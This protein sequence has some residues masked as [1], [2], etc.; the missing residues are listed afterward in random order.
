MPSPSRDARA[1]SLR[2]RWRTTVGGSPYDHRVPARSETATPTLFA[3]SIVAPLAI[4]CGLLAVAK[5]DGLGP[6]AR[7]AFRSCH[8]PPVVGVSAALSAVWV[9]W[10]SGHRRWSAGFVAFF[11]W[12]PF[13]DLIRKF[14]GN[15][16]RVYA[17]KYGLF[18]FAM[19][20]A[21]PKIRG[22]WGK[23]LGPL[24]LPTLFM[25]SVAFI[26]AIPSALS[27]PLIP[28]TGMLVRFLFIGLI[29]LGGYIGRDAARL[30]RFVFA[31]AGSSAA[32]CCVGLVQTVV[33]PEFLNPRVADAHLT[34]LL[35]SAPGV[36][37]PAFR[38]FRGREPF[39]G[40]NDHHGI[41]WS[42]RCTT[43]RHSQAN[44]LCC[45]H[46]NH[47]VG[48]R[49]RIGRTSGGRLR[50]DTG[51]IRACSGYSASARHTA[52]ERSRRSGRT[53]YRRFWPCCQ[54]ALLASS[55]AAGLTS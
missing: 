25:L 2:V 3:A 50:T 36:R 54:T 10:L 14:S 26:Y 51:G 15:D 30:R 33:G 5:V 48:R 53:C 19:F 13:E 12:L 41:V 4:A 55:P 11:V 32:V 38:A 39:R 49:F 46:D 37:R 31:L 22:L 20:A 9:S 29:G 23:T 35:L 27:D 34:H 18:A 24:Q 28:L 16:L 8:E 40:S 1:D 7:R 6:L 42:M 44:T 47:R 21:W 45:S 43:R 52:T 17:V